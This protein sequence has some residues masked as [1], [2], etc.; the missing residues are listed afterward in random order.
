MSG[1]PPVNTNGSA[2]GPPGPT[3]PTNSQPLPPVTSPKLLSAN[4]Q[5]HGVLEQ[6]GYKKASE[7]LRVSILQQKQFERA[8]QVQGDG[9][10]IESG[11][12]SGSAVGAKR[13]P[14]ASSAPGAQISQQS[15][16]PVRAQPLPVPE[17]SSLDEMLKRNLPQAFSLSSS[18]IAYPIT[19]EFMQQAENVVA[20]HLEKVQRSAANASSGAGPAAAIGQ[21]P[22]LDSVERIK[23]YVEL[24][25]WVERGLDIWKVSLA[26]CFNP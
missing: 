13:E 18:S 10:P 2:G 22:L 19:P 17:A 3:P 9:T 8:G 14:T 15:A 1:P 5:A 25:K 7:T 6:L 24:R 20:M 11:P 23:G 4:E 12:P 16:Q 21:I 26:A